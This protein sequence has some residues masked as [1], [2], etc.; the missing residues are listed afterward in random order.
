MYYVVRLN[1]DMRVH[2]TGRNMN[3]L[4]GR[5]GRACAKPTMQLWAYSCGWEP[6]IQG[7]YQMLMFFAYLVVIQAHVHS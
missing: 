2:L 5:K 3:T 7:R 6:L 1:L 4:T